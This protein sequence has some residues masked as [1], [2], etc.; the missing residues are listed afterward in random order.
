MSFILDAL[1]KAE[2]ERNLGKAPDLHAMTR[3]AMHGYG[4]EVHRYRNLRLAILIGLIVGSLVALAVLHHLRVAAR[5]P[6]L[7]AITAAPV[8]PVVA[9]ATP[10]VPPDD[11]FAGADSPL[12]PDDT[13]GSD[14]GVNSLDELAGESTVNDQQNAPR[15]LPAQVS[16]HAA[17]A[18]DEETTDAQ[19]DVGTTAA[20]TTK[21][22]PAVVQTPPAPA[23]PTSTPTTAA[24]TDTASDADDSDASNAMNAGS[25]TAPGTAT[26]KPAPDV[27]QKVSLAPAPAA[28]L[29]KDMPP[30]YRSAFPTLTVDVHSYD[31]RPGKSF[32]MINGRNYHAGDT[33]TEGPRII[34][35]VA[36]GIVFDYRGQQVLFTIG[37]H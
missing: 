18:P 17:Q 12:A 15:P 16:R 33:L 11:G 25:A 9:P 7:P 3:A 35:I 32:V 20:A 37:S 14:G 26:T 21:V 2:R 5:K 29:L 4:S 28:P 8:A 22:A 10:A 19:A 1:R 36:N 27:V 24:G 31:P 23:R 34:S 30:E 13:V 6:P